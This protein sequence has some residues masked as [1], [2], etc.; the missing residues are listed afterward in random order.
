MP[1]RVLTKEELQQRE[2]KRSV[3]NEVKERI[4][5]P[6]ALDARQKS[7]SSQGEKKE[8]GARTSLRSRLKLGRPSL[9]RELGEPTSDVDNA[10]VD[11]EKADIAHSKKSKR[12]RAKQ[13]IRSATN[14]FGSS[15]HK[16]EKKKDDDHESNGQAG[17]CDSE[18]NNTAGNISQ[19]H[20]RSSS[21]SRVSLPPPRNPTLPYDDLL[22]P[23]DGIA[24]PAVRLTTPSGS[25]VDLVV[26]DE[27]L[28]SSSCAA[29]FGTDVT[30]SDPSASVDQ[31]F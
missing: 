3:R 5:K 23:Q 12:A 14:H 25:T 22:E 18:S 4:R 1:H 13:L 9:K 27:V 15:K 29:G 2:R 30:D 6:F 7:S 28:Q 24:T 21:K 19:K 17:N 11:D 16:K 26:Y 31:D 20:I 10:A 8:K